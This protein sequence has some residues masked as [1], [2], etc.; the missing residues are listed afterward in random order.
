[1]T[2]VPCGTLLVSL[3]L[4]SWLP[5]V[6]WMLA[7]ILIYGTLKVYKNRRAKPVLAADPAC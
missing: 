4:E 5:F 3:M 1:M 6:V 7:G 2:I